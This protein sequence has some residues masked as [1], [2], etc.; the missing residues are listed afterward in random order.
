MTNGFTLLPDFPPDVLAVTGQGTID[1]SAYE[2]VLR[3]ALN[4]K[5]R[6]HAD[7]RLLYILDESFEGFTA[8]AAVSDARLGMSHLHDFSR[9]AV[10][11]DAGWVS[12]AVR[13]F[14]PLIAAPL[15]VFT[16]SQRRAE[17]TWIT[18]NDPS[19]SARAD[20]PIDGSLPV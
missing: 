18:E 7:I 20:P 12:H 5:L 9:I 8:G 10:V 2:D 17:E 11:T 1:A 15:R 3:P 14:A 16:L 13:L 19:A 6:R 4:D